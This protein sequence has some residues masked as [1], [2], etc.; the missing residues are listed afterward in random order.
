MAK[1]GNSKYYPQNTTVHIAAI[2]DRAEIFWQT[3][4]ANHLLENYTDKVS[5]FGK[6]HDLKFN[7]FKSLL[8]G[9]TLMKKQK[10]DTYIA[11]AYD[12]SKKNYYFVKFVLSSRFQ[13]RFIIIITAYATK[14]SY[15]IQAYKDYKKGIQ[16]KFAS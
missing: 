14:D 7:D 10:G 16:S 8:S 11:I 12:E 5:Q 2:K 9:N 4:N 1:S 13:R 6:D 3:V 15:Y